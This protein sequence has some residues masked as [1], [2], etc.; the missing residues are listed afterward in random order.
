VPS[1]KEQFP[2]NP[3]NWYVKK[4]SYATLTGLT[5]EIISEVLN[6]ANNGAMIESELL[7]REEADS[8]WRPKMQWV[9][10]SLSK[11]SE[12]ITQMITVRYWWYVLLQKHKDEFTEAKIID[13][14][15]FNPIDFENF[16][17]PKNKELIQAITSVPKASAHTSVSSTSSY[18]FD[19]NIM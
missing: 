12:K 17:N 11:E 18:C 15:G 7:F 14:L 6:K 8:G 1:L 3:K 2:G 13:I 19:M 4:S 5:H 16:K 9:V 10:Q